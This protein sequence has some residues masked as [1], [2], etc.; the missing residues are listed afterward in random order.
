MISNSLN[1]SSSYFFYKKDLAHRLNNF[2]N[3]KN[4]L[5]FKSRKDI[6]VA[7]WIFYIRL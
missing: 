4:K 6:L 2:E 5:K 3:A 7:E 1:W